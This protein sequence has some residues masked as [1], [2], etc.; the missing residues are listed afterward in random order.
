MNFFISETILAFAVTV[1]GV[2]ILKRKNYLSEKDVVPFTNLLIQFVIP[3]NIILMLLDKNVSKVQIEMGVIL[4]VSSILALILAYVVG[5][6]LKLKRIYI[7]ALIMTS[8][9]SASGLLGYPLIKILFPGNAMA[10]ADAIMMTEIGVGLPTLILCPIV[11]RYF[12]EQSS[13]H[14]NRQIIVSSL[15]DYFC[16]PIFI[17][18]IVGVALAFSGIGGKQGFVADMLRSALNISASG[19]TILPA[20]IIG[21]RLKK[22]T[23][24]H[25]LP[26]I[27]ASAA[28]QMFFE[29]CTT[30]Y[31]A[32]LMHLQVT[33]KTVLLLLSMMPSALLAPVFASRYEC[34]PDET[35]TIVFVNIILSVVLVPLLYRLLF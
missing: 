14:T 15:K 26:L 11:A 2:I 13:L 21:L 16:S 18:I 27:V 17:S 19:L 29:P 5:R 35:A 23:I 6:L 31:F 33:E 34:A 7:G 24:G 32:N 12:G 30:A 1:I 25:I 8:A 10:I 4:F 3:A 20:V 22:M 9:F 28:I